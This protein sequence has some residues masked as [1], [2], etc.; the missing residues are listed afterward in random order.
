MSNFSTSMAAIVSR[1][2]PR[3]K[4]AGFKKRR[5]TFNRSI[6]PGVVQVIGFQ[7][8]S[9][10][11][12]GAEPIPP[13]RLDLHGQFTVNLGVAIKEAWELSRPKLKFPVFLNDYD[14]E[15]RERLGQLIGR[16][17]DTW[18]PLNG[19]LDLV[20]DEVGAAIVE[21]ALQWLE[22]RGTRAKILGLAQQ[23]GLSGLPLPTALPIVM[24]LRQEGREEE[25]ADFLR[26][27]YEPLTHARHRDYVYK[28]AEK[29]GIEGLSTP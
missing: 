5:H 20:A 22:G 6:E 8:G 14:C 18:W 26:T 12:P 10:L 23:A 29:L 4:D 11:P 13:I 3:L 9:K 21:N 16:R 19:A 27:Y 1:L 28:V 17:T 25:A 7:M 15:I 2:H 24:I